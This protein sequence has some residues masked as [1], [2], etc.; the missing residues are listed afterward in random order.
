MKKLT[1]LCLLVGILSGCYTQLITRKVETAPPVQSVSFEVDSLTGDTVKV[2]RQVDTV[3]ER[4]N[5]HCYWIQNIWGEPELR[6]DNSYYSQSWYQYNNYPWWYGRNFYDPY[7]GSNY[8]A[9]RGFYHPYY[10]RGG[11]Y[12]GRSGH[13]VDTGNGKPR[14]TSSSA[15]S[16]DPIIT[17]SDENS[18][19]NRGSIIIKRSEDASNPPVTEERR[20]RTS[21]TGVSKTI[22][23]TPAVPRLEQAPDIK[24]PT[25]TKSPE[26]TPPQP[27]VDVPPRPASTNSTP[28]D[29][30]TNRRKPTRRW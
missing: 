1:V 8:Y 20:R 4:D 21:S 11:R 26:P 19:R 15:V 28:P 7:Y 3:V 5:Q 2:V 12:N 6:C 13:T 22:T 27:K 9:G 16:K 10:Y 18:S 24:T 14:R 30:T 25:L 29:N 23:A 17:N